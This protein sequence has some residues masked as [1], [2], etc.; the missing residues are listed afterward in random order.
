MSPSI[1]KK[2]VFKLVIWQN[3]EK[4][5]IFAPEK[6]G[7]N[8]RIEEWYGESKK[9]PP[10]TVYECKMKK[11][12]PDEIYF[13]KH[14]AFEVKYKLFGKQWYIAIQPEWYFSSDGY[15]KSFYAKEKI[16]WLKKNEN[17]RTVF[18]HVK[19]IAYFLKYH[20]H[21]D[22]FKERKEYKFLSFGDMVVFNNSPFLDD[23]DWLP[24][25]LS[26]VQS[27]FEQLSLDIEL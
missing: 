4:L 2:G 18:N 15:K 19:F 6:E 17:N 16:D 24:E 14:F 3:Q 7:D 10:R 11:N 12:K 21:S 25:K 1:I 9:N 13:C 23:K 26:D 8:K 5:Y 20:K 27:D 22:I